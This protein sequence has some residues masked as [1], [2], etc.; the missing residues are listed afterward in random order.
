VIAHI[1][2]LQLYLFWITITDVTKFSREMLRVNPHLHMKQ[3]WQG[4]VALSR[5]LNIWN[6]WLR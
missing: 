1:L 4:N 3:D 5:Y 2:G 6:F